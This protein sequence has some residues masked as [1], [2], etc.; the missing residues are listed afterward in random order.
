MRP[1]HAADDRARVDAEDIGDRPRAVA[2]K[3]IR[4][5]DHVRSIPDQLLGAHLIGQDIGHHLLD[6]GD[7][8]E[9]ADEPRRGEAQLAAFGQALA[10]EGELSAWVE[11]PTQEV[12][13]VPGPDV[14]LAGCGRGRDVDPV[15]AQALE[16]GAPLGR[17]DDVNR[18]IT[19][20]EALHDERH[21]GAI[22]VVDAV[23]QQDHVTIA[24]L[25]T[26][27]MHGTP[28]RGHGSDRAS[29]ARPHV[30]TRRARLR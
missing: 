14:E 10:E 29:S 30:R 15:R 11:R 8:V 25:L 26:G 28:R 5:H 27:Q 3:V 17:I 1:G 4:A 24:K 9:A 18:A 12:C 20:L 2:S 13:L 22:D 19:D 21:E 6:V 16:V 23:S 7:P